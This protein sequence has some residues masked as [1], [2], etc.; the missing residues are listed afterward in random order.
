MGYFVLACLLIFS[1]L[2]SPVDPLIIQLYRVL[3]L[4][5]SSVITIFISERIE[6]SQIELAESE[7]KYRNIVETTH[8]GVLTGDMNGNILYVYLKGLMTKKEE[9]NGKLLFSNRI[10]TRSPGKSGAK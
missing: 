5:S 4:I 9:E 6:K 1:E 2:I 10:I 3:I 7:E 8:E